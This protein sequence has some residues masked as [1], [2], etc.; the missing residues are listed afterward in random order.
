MTARADQ[1]ALC[2]LR[3]DHG[4]V[5][6]L[7]HEVRDVRTLLSTHVVVL[8]SAGGEAALTIRAGLLLKQLDAPL[9]FFSIL[10]LSRSTT[11][12]VRSLVRLVVLAR[13]LALALLTAR[14]APLPRYAPVELVHRL[15]LL[16]ACA[17][18]HAGH[19]NLPIWY[20]AV[21]PRFKSFRAL[22][23]PRTTVNRIVFHF[24]KASIGRPE[25]PPWV[26]KHRGQTHYVWHLDAAP[27]VGFSTKET[28]ENPSTQ[29]AIQFRGELRLVEVDGKLHARIEA[30]A[31]TA[32]AVPS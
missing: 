25:I 2:D 21:P 18:F 16:A 12:E 20:R 17:D 4:P 26:I 13:D 6:S 8:H 23:L 7:L 32:A 22:H 5:A 31:P 30:S 29:G 1:V 27:G 9:G 15:R 19:G 28:P 3:R 24:N 10:F 11:L 14:V